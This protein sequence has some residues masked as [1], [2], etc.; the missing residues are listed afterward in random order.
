MFT[1]DDLVEIVRLREQEN[2]SYRKIASKF[3]VSVNAIGDFF[4]RQSYNHFWEQHDDKPIARG[5]VLKPDDKRKKLA[6]GMFVLTSAQNNTY[7][8]DKWL[9]S[10]ETYCEHN[11]AKLIVGGF[12]YDLSGRQVSQKDDVWYDPKI[13]KYM[14][15][16]S[17]QIAKG[18]VWCGELNILPT[19]KDPLSGLDN[20][21]NHDCSIVP[22]AK[23]Q[24]KSIATPKV[25][26]ARLMY[27]TGCVTQRNYIQKKAGQLAEHHHSFS[28]LV[29]EVDSDGDWF[30]RQISAEKLT[31][32]FYDLTDRYTPEGVTHN[33]DVEAI[34]FGDIHSAKPD[35]VVSSVSWIESDSML[36]VLRPKYVFLHDTLD[37]QAR[38]HHNVRDPHFMFAMHHNKTESVKGE[39]STTIDTINQFKRDFCTTVIVESN[40]DKSIERWLKEQ[41]YRQDPV[42][43]VFFLELQLAKYKSIQNSEN[44]SA[45]ESACKMAGYDGNA[46]FLRE[47]DTFMIANG[48]ECAA[49][50]HL[51]SNGGKG[52]VQAYVKTGVRHNIGHSH[53]A[54][55]KDGVWQAGVSGSLDMGYNS[56]NSSWSHSHIVT[57]K[58]GKRAMVTIKNGKWRK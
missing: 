44:F 45:F 14:I 20:H 58:N 16:E 3:D 12:T 47:D 1:P 54:T 36:D 11:D 53:S 34:N 13:T 22:H 4:R 30:V 8:H 39:I 42:N 27:T 21:T 2:L 38:N 28:A 37:Q 40:H 52:G 18:L 50:S 7:V 35:N 26:G 51:G 49:H 5:T 6:G 15:D 29:V 19:A 17:M 10:L 25:M 46:I 57:Y 43:A 33:H 31:G 55:I 56:G 9:K 23:L 32:E 48:I 24:M 41:D